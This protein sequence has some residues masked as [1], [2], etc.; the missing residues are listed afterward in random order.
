MCCNMQYLSF[1]QDKVITD[2]LID[3][4]FYSLYLPYLVKNEVMKAEID[5]NPYMQL[6]NFRECH[7]VLLGIRN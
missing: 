7:F 1:Y 6:Y 2:Y 5:K 4:N 3:I